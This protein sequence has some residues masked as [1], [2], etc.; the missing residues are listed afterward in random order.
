MNLFDWWD[1]N[2]H[3]S[4][5]IFSPGSWENFISNIV[6]ILNEGTPTP[7]DCLKEKTSLFKFLITNLLLIHQEKSKPN[8]NSNKSQS[9]LA[10]QIPASHTIKKFKGCVNLQ[11][12]FISKR[13]I[14]LKLK[15]HERL[16]EK[17][18][19]TF[20]VHWSYRNKIK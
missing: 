3:N 7:A 2:L 14:I 11:L 9:Q 20:L 16:A 19:C 8:T 10:T 5:S 18:T 1:T 12:P 17:N 6:A 13:S 15:K 4:K